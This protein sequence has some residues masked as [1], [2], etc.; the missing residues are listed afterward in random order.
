MPAASECQKGENQKGEWG[1]SAKGILSS[2][3]DS[4][5]G[6]AQ[7]DARSRK[8]A[9]GPRDQRTIPMGEQP[10]P[11]RAIWRACITMAKK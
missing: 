3:L 4:R 11:E 6:K 1:E 7:G 2:V 8:T 5:H 9:Q 10:T